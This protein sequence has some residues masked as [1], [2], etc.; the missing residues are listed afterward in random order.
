MKKSYLGVGLL[1]IVLAAC[2]GGDGDDTTTTQ[3][4]GVDETTTTTPT[5]GGAGAGGDFCDF[6][7]DYAE[8]ADFS[9]VGIS[10]TQIEQTLMGSLDA[11]NQGLELA[12]SEIKADVA[13]FADAYAGFVD[14]LGE[15]EYNF[16]SIPEDAFDDPRLAALEDPE[17]EAAGQQ[18][19][20]FCGIDDFITPG[21]SGPTGSGSLPGASLPEDFP[22]G[23][24]PPGG[25]VVASVEAGGATS[26]TFDTEM[27]SDDVIAF[28]TDLLGPPTQ[29]LDEPKGALWFTEYEG[30][31]LS[32]VVAEIG[33]NMTQVNVTLQ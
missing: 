5:S 30:V 10:P 16:L 24:E 6:L 14:F 1:V 13:L 32:L 19:E 7:V 20:E 31:T 9:P 26:V 17:L 27:S 11:I 22:P 21:P 15:Y 33:P 23:L 25:V 4:G 29:Q 28:Y 3:A 8:N 18:I 2:G 12:P